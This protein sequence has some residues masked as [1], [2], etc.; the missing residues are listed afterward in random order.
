MRIERANAK[1]NLY[2]DVVGKRENGYHDIVSIMQTLSLC[3]L[4]SVDFRPDLHTSIHLTASGNGA[5]PTDCRNLAWRAAERYLMATGLSGEVRIS[6]EKH[7]PMAAGLAGGS[8]D[9]AAVLRALN[10]L[11]GERLTL[12]ELCELGA[13]LG[14]DIP[15]CIRGGCARVTGIG[16]CLEPLP[17]MSRMPL[18]VACMGEGIS[19]PYG[20]GRLD[21]L[22]GNFREKHADDGR[23]ARLIAALQDGTLAAN[24]DTLYNIFEPVV[25]EL[26][27]GVGK[28]RDTMLASGATCAMMSGSGPSVFGIFSDVNAAAAAVEA[29]QALGAAAFLCHPTASYFA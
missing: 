18:A 16:E 10:R 23:P 22:Y 4:I 8:A 12:G 14:A 28:L 1:I 25:S 2:L 5:M 3:D 15:F 27:P 9:A 17:A 20:Y 13:G 26:R 21:E 29:L 7:I 19:T 6:I 11:C 24:V